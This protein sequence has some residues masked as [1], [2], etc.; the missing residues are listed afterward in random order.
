MAAALDNQRLESF[1]EP[2]QNITLIAVLGF[3]YSPLEAY[4]HERSGSI[5]VSQAAGYCFLP[6]YIPTRCIEGLE[7][8][9]YVGHLLHPLYEI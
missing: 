1:A 5:W 3:S 7:P 6:S 2:L 4:G 9:D 8:E